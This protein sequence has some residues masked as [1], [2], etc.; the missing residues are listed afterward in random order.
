VGYRVQEKTINLSPPP[1]MRTTLPMQ[2]LEKHR[3]AM[4]CLKGLFGWRKER[5][6]LPLFLFGSF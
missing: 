6:I 4:G 2:N 1:S 5:K 3:Q